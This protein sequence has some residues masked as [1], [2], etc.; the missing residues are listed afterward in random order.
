MSIGRIIAEFFVALLKG[1]LGREEPE[2]H[3]TV[4]TPEKSPLPST[5]DDLRRKLDELGRLRR[6]RGRP[7]V[8]TEVLIV[9]PGAP[10]T[11]V[12]NVTVTGKLPG[13]DNFVRQDIGGWVAMPGEHFDALLDALDKC[14]G[15]L[16]EP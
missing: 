3:E 1:L 14:H 4:V 10:L 6:D 16:S 12:E 15:S 11:V 8:R 7:R 2:K 13:T 9:K 5:A